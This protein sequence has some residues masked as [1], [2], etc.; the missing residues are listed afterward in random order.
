MTDPRARTLRCAF[1]LDNCNLQLATDDDSAEW[2]D[3][4]IVLLN[5]TSLTRMDLKSRQ[6]SWSFTAAADAVAAGC[7]VPRT[8]SE[9]V[10]ISQKESKEPIRYA[11]QI[12]E[13]L[14]PS[15]RP[16]LITDSA[17]ELE[18]HNGSRIIALP[19]KPP[20]GKR[21]RVYLDELAHVVHSDVA[22]FRGAMG[23]IARGGCVRGGSTPLGPRGLFW[24][25][26]TR[27][28]DYPGWE[29]GIWPWWVFKGFST[30]PEGAALV[31][32]L[33]T[34]DEMVEKYG[35]ARIKAIR[36]GYGSDLDGFLQEHCCAWVTDESSFI[37]LEL[38][39]SCELDFTP[40]VQ[41]DGQ[42]FIGFDVGRRRDL[43]AVVGVEKDKAG[44]RV[45]LLEVW[46]QMPFP[47]QED[48]LTAILE[49]LRPARTAGDYTG[50]GGP[51]VERLQERFGKARVE[52]VTFT[53]AMKEDLA[54][55]LKA[56]L[57]RRHITVPVDRALRSD[58]TSI[59][60]TRT[61]AGNY[62]YDGTSEDGHADRAWALALA[63]HAAGPLERS[64]R[65]VEAELGGE[66][67]FS[68]DG[69]VDAWGDPIGARHEWG[70]E[71]RERVLRE[72]WGPQGHSKY[73]PVKKER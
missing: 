15:V 47:E 44:A 64:S 39:T 67:V 48:R 62:R 25:V 31:A 34:P 18:F 12:I 10:S 28:E 57:E 26:C 21:A 19:A 6:A 56:A 7:L 59:R 9:I 32:D 40:E 46:K 22:V 42:V 35:T 1:I 29:M 45:C 14:H 68:D 23:A 73:Y 53:G 61:P 17:S 65:G 36:S 60:Q 41:G 8:T 30:D 2:E 16:K 37:P 70:T 49:K 3:M 72:F 71:D 24:K 4:Q 13:A 58:I 33:L 52:A 11:R 43:S 54:T 5:E 38:L 66:R 27:P 55:G 51:I 63:I 50:M 69:E 20:R